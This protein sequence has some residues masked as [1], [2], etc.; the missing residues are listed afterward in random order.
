MKSKVLKLL[1][2]FFL[3]SSIGFAREIDEKK[4]SKFDYISHEIYCFF[5]T[6]EKEIDNNFVLIKK[7]NNQKKAEKSDA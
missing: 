6:C 5:A 7:E 1:L 3:F 2:I 4:V